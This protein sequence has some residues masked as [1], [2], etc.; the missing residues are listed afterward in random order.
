MSLIHVR[1]EDWPSLPPDLAYYLGWYFWSPWVLDNAPHDD[2][3]FRGYAEMMTNIA[4]WLV[5]YHRLPA[6]V[7][8]AWLPWYH[9]LGLAAA[10]AMPPAPVAAAVTSPGGEPSPRQPAKPVRPISPAS[11]E[12][13]RGAIGT[14]YRMKGPW[15][16]AAYRGLCSRCGSPIEPGEKIRADGDG[17][18]EC[19]ECDEQ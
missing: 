9:R 12:G 11:A 5:A 10:A 8:V 2:R 15:F 19:R 14:L 4:W 16:Y 6:D 18:W 17:G 3:L 1:G 7:A 13:R